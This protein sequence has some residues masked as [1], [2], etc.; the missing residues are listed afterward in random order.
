M[1]A[2]ITFTK[3]VDDAIKPLATEL[4]NKPTQAPELFKKLVMAV[5]LGPI[6]FIAVVLPKMILRLELLASVVI[7]ALLEASACVAEVL[8]ATFAKAVESA[9]IE[10][11][12]GY[13]AV[14]TPIIFARTVGKLAAKYEL[15]MN[16]AHAVATLEMAAT[17]PGCAD[18][19][20]I[21]ELLAII[22]VIATVLLATIDITDV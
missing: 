18:I 10:L 19:A 6:T 9:I 12:V 7:A 2:A 15:P 22:A 3:A 14:L 16:E 5:V 8:A 20:A 17:A 1:L 4:E 13:V 11:S 21:D